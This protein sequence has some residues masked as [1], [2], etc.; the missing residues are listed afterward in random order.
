[1]SNITTPASFVSEK[2]KA[3][4]EPVKPVNETKSVPSTNLWADADSDLSDVTDDAD[5]K[6]RDGAAL[7]L[8]AHQTTSANV[9][10]DTNTVPSKTSNNPSKV[11]T[12]FID[13][14]PKEPDTIAAPKP[15]RNDS[16]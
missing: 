8:E 1:M 15:T 3:L 14:K 7:T 10:S 12:V 16:E 4:V 9:R 11:Q 6:P 13:C 2:V 5:E